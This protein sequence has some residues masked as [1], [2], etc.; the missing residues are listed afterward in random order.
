M[1][2][3]LPSVLV[4]ERKP[5]EDIVE[6]EEADECVRRVEVQN[7]DWEVEP[8]IEKCLVIPIIA[9]ELFDWERPCHPRG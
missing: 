7:G 5:V 6:G 4:V 1:G 3:S 9:R 8:V 2:L